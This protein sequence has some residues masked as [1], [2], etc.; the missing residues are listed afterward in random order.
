MT[1]LTFGS[2][3][4]GIGGMDLG[5]ERAGMVCKWQCEIDDYAVKV[6]EKHWPN[7]H[8]V[9]D[10]RS[11]LTTDATCFAEGSLAKTSALPETAQESPASA[12]DCGKNSSESFAWFD[13]DSSSWKTSQRCL[14]E[15]W[16]PFLE[17]WPRAGLMRNG[18]C[19]RQRRLV[20][21]ISAR[22]FSY[23]PTVTVSDSNGGGRNYKRPGKNGENL[24]DFL[25]LKYRVLYVPATLAEF[26]MGF[27][28]GWTALDASAIASCP[29]S[30]SGSADES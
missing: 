6:L 11:L 9:R 29:P 12:A 19:Y 5:L 17:T 30:P 23:W 16:K 4:A 21:R 10:V 26:L 7:V 15:E 3:F 8:R 18:K 1:P 22:G 14:V 24:K 28:I 25:S 2:L 27:P 20:H 13:R